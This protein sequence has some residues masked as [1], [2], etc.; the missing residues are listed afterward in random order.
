MNNSI[1]LQTIN[2]LKQAEFV[3]TLGG[4]FEHSPWVA[5]QAFTLQPFSSIM[6]LHE[7]MK[8]IVDNADQQH[9]K[10]LICNHPELA[11]REAEAGE[12]TQDSKNE[13][14]AA[15]LS[16]C[17]AEE[18]HQLRKLNKQYREKFDFP[19]VVAVKQLTRYDILD[20]ITNRLQNSLDIEF[21]NCIDEIGKIAE[22]RLRQLIT[23]E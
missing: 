2:S 9:R 18:L 11:G 6:Q 5:E 3:N 4:I 17:S 16:N 19:F 22:F 15:G 21:K 8:N 1:T 12:L 14:A 7:S 23:T 13:Q 10:D 20:A